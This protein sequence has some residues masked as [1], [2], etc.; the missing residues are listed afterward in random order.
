M[1]RSGQKRLLAYWEV[2]GE[3]ARLIRQPLDVLGWSE[4]IRCLQPET[5]E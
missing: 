3:E 4:A 2:S 5:G 1:R